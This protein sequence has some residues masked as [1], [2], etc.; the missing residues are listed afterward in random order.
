MCEIF[1]QFAN[2]FTPNTYKVQ[3]NWAINTEQHA[4]FLNNSLVT[5]CVIIT[6]NIMLRYAICACYTYYI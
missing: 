2:K 6:S 5:G 4:N 1:E 3:C